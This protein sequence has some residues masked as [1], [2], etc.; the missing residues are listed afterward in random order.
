MTQMLV[1]GILDGPMQDVETD[2]W[3]AVVSAE[4]E[5]EMLKA[6]MYFK[7]EDDA[8][9]IVNHFRTSIQPIEVNTEEDGY[10]V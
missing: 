7:S 4:S 1:H 5:G 2:D 10:D 9:Y 3:L 8:M 6:L